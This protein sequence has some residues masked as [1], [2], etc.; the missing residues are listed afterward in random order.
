[1]EDFSFW[2]NSTIG[3]LVTFQCFRF[4]YNRPLTL[5]TAGGLLALF[6]ISMR[7]TVS[8]ILKVFGFFV[9][10]GG[11]CCTKFVILL[12]IIAVMLLLV[13]DAALAVVVVVFQLHS[14]LGMI[15]T[16][17]DPVV[18]QMGRYIADNGLQMLI[19]LGTAIES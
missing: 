6:V 13:V 11:G 8:V 4:A 16:E 7:I 10:Y 19:I 15:E 18:Q 12:Q 9:T 5:A 3:S 1:M 2:V 14:N 17:Q